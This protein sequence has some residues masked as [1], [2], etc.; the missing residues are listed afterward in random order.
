MNDEQ[1]NSEVTTRKVEATPNGN[2]SVAFALS[3]SCLLLFFGGLFAMASPFLFDGGV[4]GWGTN[5]AEME[6]QRRGFSV[7]FDGFYS[8]AIGVFV[9]AVSSICG[10]FIGVVA[11]LTSAF[12]GSR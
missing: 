12:R 8:F 2:G 9:T 6:P 7:M 10:M 3:L 1:S 5:Y 11:G 4:A